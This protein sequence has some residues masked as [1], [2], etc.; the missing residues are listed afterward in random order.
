MTTGLRGAT[1]TGAWEYLDRHEAQAWGLDYE[2]LLSGTLELPGIRRI[3]EQ[4]TNYPLFW[5][6]GFFCMA[7]LV[8]QFSRVGLS[9]AGSDGSFGERLLLEPLV[10]PGRFA[11]LVDGCAAGFLFI[12]LGLFVTGLVKRWAEPGW[13]LQRELGPEEC[14]PLGQPPRNENSPTGSSAARQLLRWLS[15]GN[16]EG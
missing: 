4:P 8:A 10:D 14:A 7:S 6:I 1:G 15:G 11:G 3:F 2:A 16:P 5:G 9:W 13:A 12:G